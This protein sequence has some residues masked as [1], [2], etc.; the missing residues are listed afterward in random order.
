M[1][2]S[3]IEDRDRRGLPG[4]EIL[5]PTPAFIAR[6]RDLYRQQI[7]LR[8]ADPYPCCT[9]STSPA[10]GPSTSTRR[11][12]SSRRPP[13][14]ESPGGRRC[15]RMD[16]KLGRCRGRPTDHRD[17]ARRGR[18]AR[19]AKRVRDVDRSI[20]RLVE[21]M[22]DSMHA[23]NGVGLAAPQIGV[24]L[25]VIVIGLPDQ[26]PFALLNPEVVKRSGERQM[27]EG[28]LS[29]PGYRGAVTRATRVVV[30]ATD[31]QGREIRI[32]AEGDL[33]AQALEHEINHI[34]GILYIDQ[35]R[36]PD[37]LR[38]LVPG[39]RDAED[40]APHDG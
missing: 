30:K 7:T 11:G 3:L 5:G 4:P 16:A 6:R 38:R 25:R 22:I 27:P 10:A 17:P 8:G 1:A 9:A 36:D 35:V 28:C 40:I 29:V 33:L 15:A 20:H 12:C 19:Q 39:E 31:L 2:A 26:E 13:G 37:D 14:S 21:D 32:R 23:A 24:S 18:A 34:N